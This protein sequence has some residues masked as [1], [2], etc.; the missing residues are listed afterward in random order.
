MRRHPQWRRLIAGGIDRVVRS[1]ATGIT[2]TRY[3]LL[4][5]GLDVR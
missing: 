2:S 5:R 4:I 3:D 1:A